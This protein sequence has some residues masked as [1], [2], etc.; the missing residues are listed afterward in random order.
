MKIREKK[1]LQISLTGYEILL[2]NVPEAVKT[3]FSFHI[4]KYL[5]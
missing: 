3:P 2:L 1:P 4:G 5:F